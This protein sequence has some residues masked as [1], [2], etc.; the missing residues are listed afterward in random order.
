MII[1]EVSYKRLE[2]FERMCDYA[3]AY[4]DEHPTIAHKRATENAI[5]DIRY[6]IKLQRMIYKNIPINNGVGA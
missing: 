3:E 4:I 5:R 1:P 2:N 6:G